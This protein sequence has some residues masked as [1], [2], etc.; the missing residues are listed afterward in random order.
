MIELENVKIKCNAKEF[1][2]K[3]IEPT[4]KLSEEVENQTT[5]M[6]EFGSVHIT[7]TLNEIRR[8]KL[9]TYYRKKDDSAFSDNEI[10]D[11]PTWVRNGMLKK[12]D[13]SEGSDVEFQS[14]QEKPD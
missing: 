8:I 6:D 5:S 7:K 2:C 13:S 11:L 1:E 14:F 9:K 10:D 4:V 12:I 3:F